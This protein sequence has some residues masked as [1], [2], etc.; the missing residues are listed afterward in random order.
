VAKG[1]PIYKLTQPNAKLSDSAP[2]IL[3]RLQEMYDFA[4]AMRD[5]A[6]VN[7]L[8]DMR[9]A[10]KR[11]RYTMEVFAPCF[12]AGFARALKTVEEIQERLGAI[13]D[14]DVLI[15]LLQATLQKETERERKKA[16][17]K[18]GGPP[19]F[20]AAEGLAPLIASKRAERDRRFH[21]F[22]AFWDGLDPDG[23]FARVQRVIGERPSSVA[24]DGGGTDPAATAAFQEPQPPRTETV[25][26][27]GSS[28]AAS[29]AV[30]SPMPSTNGSDAA[31]ADAAAS[32]VMPSLSVPPVDPI[33]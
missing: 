10:A 15:P 9:I 27:P 2:V 1:V 21:E 28:P 16:L 20:V 31:S 32:A 4:P 25:S 17:R 6:N 18:G 30:S 12:G 33:A 13:H 29:D 19:L 3:V 24:G 8:H 11:L 5:P 14:C 23:F 22:V 7:D 26:D